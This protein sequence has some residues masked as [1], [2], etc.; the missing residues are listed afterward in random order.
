LELGGGTAEA[1]R[2]AELNLR[3]ARLEAARLRQQVANQRLASRA[4]RREL[5]FTV[6]MQQ[7]SIA[8]QAAK[9]R[10]ADISSQLPGVLTWVNDNLGATVQAG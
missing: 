5:G 7:R 10:E 6:S 1:V 3:T 2:Q 9:L 4:D 8:E